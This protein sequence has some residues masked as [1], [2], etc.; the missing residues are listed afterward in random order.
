M[1]RVRRPW[2][3]M[4][5]LQLHFDPLLQ[6]LLHCSPNRGQILGSV[7]LF[8]LDASQRRR[9]DSERR[10]SRRDQFWKRERIWQRWVVEYSGWEMGVVGRVS[11]PAWALPVAHRAEDGRGRQ[12]SDRKAQGALRRGDVIRMWGGGRGEGGAQSKQTFPP[13]ELMLPGP[14]PAEHGIWTLMGTQWIFNECLKRWP[15]EWLRILIYLGMDHLD[16]LII[17]R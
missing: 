4:L 7:H 1:C 14:V 10:G 12:T 15:T 16:N 13:S 5:R 8:M 17:K 6:F 3:D 2:E 11:I 9:E